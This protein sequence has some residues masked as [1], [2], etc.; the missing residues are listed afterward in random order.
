MKFVRWARVR[1]PNQTQVFLATVYNL[2]TL[3][4]YKA[5]PRSPR[6]TISFKHFH[7]HRLFLSS[8]ELEK[9]S[10]PRLSLKTFIMRFAPHLLAATLALG[11]ILGVIAAP[12][13]EPMMPSDEQYD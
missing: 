3:A 10:I 9:L 1:R 5:A 2:G 13:A 12:V 7:Q 11:S 8:S 4:P 6:G